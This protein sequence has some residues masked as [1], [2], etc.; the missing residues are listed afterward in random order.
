VSYHLTSWLKK[1][2]YE[3]GEIFPRQVVRGFF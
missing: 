1:P 3:S 2:G